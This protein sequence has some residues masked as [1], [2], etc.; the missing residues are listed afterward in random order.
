MRDRPDPHAA[1]RRVNAPGRRGRAGSGAREEQE[2]EDSMTITPLRPRQSGSLLPPAIDLES[3]RHVTAALTR[4]GMEA[5]T[6]ID[7]AVGTERHERLA[8]TIHANMELWGSLLHA[9]LDGSSGAPGPLRSNLIEFAEVSIRH[10]SYVL[11]GDAALDP[12][13]AVNRSIIERLQPTGDKRAAGA[14]R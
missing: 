4:C 9:V 7:P 3:F 8:R 13:I 5:T 14:D 10:D 11:R 6:A 1:E 2:P 12:L